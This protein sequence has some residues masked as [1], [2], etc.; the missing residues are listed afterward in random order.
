MSFYRERI[1]PHLVTLLG[2][3]KPIAQIRQSI[4]PLAQGDVLE[5]GVGTGMNFPLYDAARVQKVYALEPNKGM[6]LR[7]DEQR[8]RLTLRVEFLDLPRETHSSIGREC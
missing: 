5:V 4:V 6:L 2:N 8:S 7:A 1:Y 3:P